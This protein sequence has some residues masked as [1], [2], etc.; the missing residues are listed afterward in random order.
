MD[1]EDKEEYYSEEVSVVAT[2]VSGVGCSETVGC[3][4]H[5]AGVGASIDSSSNEI[6]NLADISASTN[7]LLRPYFLEEYSFNIHAICLFL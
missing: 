1:Q 3:S 4:H 5:S 2:G 7:S 6:P